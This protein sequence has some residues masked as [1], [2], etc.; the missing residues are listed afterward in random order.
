MVD[1]VQADESLEGTSGLE[2][3]CQ[4]RGAKLHQ[5]QM[6]AFRVSAGIKWSVKKPYTQSKSQS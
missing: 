4:I 6:R 2:L 3:P 1:R 5:S